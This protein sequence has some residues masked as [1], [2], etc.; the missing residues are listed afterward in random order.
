LNFV[1]C[2]ICLKWATLSCNHPTFCSILQDLENQI[3]LFELVLTLWKHKQLH[4]CCA[5]NH[6]CYTICLSSPFS[7]VYFPMIDMFLKWILFWSQLV[8]MFNFWENFAIHNV[9]TI[10]KPNL[11]FNPRQLDYIGNLK[12]SFWLI[13]TCGL[14]SNIHLEDCLVY[15]GGWLKKLITFIF[16]TMVIFFFGLFRPICVQMGRWQVS[17]SLLSGSIS[18]QSCYSCVGVSMTMW[19]WE[20][21]FHKYLKMLRVLSNIALHMQHATRN[22]DDKYKRSKTKRCVET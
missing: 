9:H 3:D 4:F 11:Q 10:V 15:N 5:Y 18:T 8:F 13:N 19:R 17:L 14:C 2:Y 7:W 22:P 16:L 21:T 20:N 6:Y 1:E 12:F